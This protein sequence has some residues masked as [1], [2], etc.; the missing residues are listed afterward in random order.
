MIMFSVSS[1]PWN[2]A[3]YHVEHNGDEALPAGLQTK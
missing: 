1:A 3:Q 2:K